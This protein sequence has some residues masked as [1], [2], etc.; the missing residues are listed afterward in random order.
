MRVRLAGTGGPEGW[1]VPGCRCASCGRVPPGHRRPLSV[2]VDDRLRLGAV[3]GRPSPGEPVRSGHGHR[4]ID[5]SEPGHLGE[6]GDD[7][8]LRDAAAPRRGDEVGAPSGRDA[9]ADASHA[10]IATADGWLVTGPD[11]TRLLHAFPLPDGSFPADSAQSEPTPPC[12]LVLIDVLDRPERLGDLRRRGVAHERTVLVAVGIDHRVPSEAELARR[13]AMWGVTSVP[14]E[15]VLEVR[16]GMVEIPQTTTNS[17]GTPHT[18]TAAEV[19]PQERAG[20]PGTPH[21]EATEVTPQERAGSPDRPHT[22]AAAEVTPQE[23]AGS[24]GTLHTKAAEVTPEERAG[25]PGP[26][27]TKAAAEV[28]LQAYT[29]R[30]DT[31]HAQT[32]AEATPR[33]YTSS[34]GTPRTRAAAMVTARVRAGGVES[35]GAWPNPVGHRRPRRTLLL[36]G[37]GS[38]KSAEAEL[39]LAGLP[40]VVYVATG[41]SGVGDAEWQARVRAHRER[42][43]PHW[44]TVETVDVAG[45][46]RDGTAALLVD[47]LGTWLAAV[48]DACDAWESAAGREGVARRCD[49]L[50]DAWRHTAHTVVAVSDEVGLGVVPASASGRRFRDALG[51]LNQR[52]AAESEE[53]ALVVAGRL[54][55]LPT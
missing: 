28:T 34:P 22:K 7:G 40:E 17:V 44:R 52:L 19:T 25:S 24:P 48:F 2:V 26:P 46:L 21:T 8:R 27:H 14:D 11:G 55:P 23:R 38:G 35:P 43:P 20:S 41:P 16:P 50:V 36:G 4:S 45:M 42:R 31:P 10:V 29:G 5:A 13:L 32:T 53:V 12:D 9:A 15:T 6:S 1:P 54:L 51:R 30:P 39:R 18:R 47:G 49:E 3:G 33:A 37:S